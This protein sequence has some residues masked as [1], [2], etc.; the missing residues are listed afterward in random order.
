MVERQDYISYGRLL[1]LSRK[2][3]VVIDK[4]R[5]VHLHLTESNERQYMNKLVYFIKV[6]FQFSF[7]PQSIT[8]PFQID[9]FK[10][11][12]DTNDNRNA[13]GR[14]FDPSTSSSYATPSEIV[15]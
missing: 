11:I 2:S 15:G 9:P 7:R 14:D 3:K 5:T 6:S 1:Y 12:N 8:V 10:D 13:G 4:S